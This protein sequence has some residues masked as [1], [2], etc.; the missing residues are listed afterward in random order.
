MRRTRTPSEHLDLLVAGSF[1]NSFALTARISGSCTGDQLAHAL[2]AMTARHPLLAVRVLPRPWPLKAVLSSAKVPT[3][4]LRVIADAGE[5]DWLTVLRSE[6]QQPFDL[7]RGPL[8]RLV[9]LIG[10][11]FFDL[12]VV[13]SHVTADGGALQYLLGDLLSRLADPTGPL[14]LSRPPTGWEL[15]DLREEAADTGCAPAGSASAAG[16]GFFARDRTAEPGP[17]EVYAGSL[18]PARSGRLVRRCRAEST[19]VHA[20]LCVALVRALAEVEPGPGLRRLGCP[21]SLRDQLPDSERG[22]FGCYG[23]PAAQVA[24]D[25]SA[26][27]SVWEAARLFKTELS[28]QSSATAVANGSRWLMR[29][30][31]AP[32]WRA[33]RGVRAMFAG[34]ADLWVSNLGVLPVPRRYGG[35]EV[36][37]VRL[38]VNTGPADRRVIGVTE[39]G[40]E[41]F[42]TGISSDGTLMRR[43]IERAVE[44]LDDALDSAAPNHAGTVQWP[45]P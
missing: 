28:R 12:L 44:V 25:P 31:A 3:P 42:L 29:F 22:A 16:S 24:V 27:V 33:R 17:L 4:P 5:A 37:Q 1:S 35:F 9:L 23:G 13:T 7:G 10:D 2:D 14:V 34:D 36:Q 8:T 30:A 6:L 45:R 38:A 40:G 20:A 15:V 32:T 19:T 39:T 18:E 11:G 41:V 21:F 43:L 26:D